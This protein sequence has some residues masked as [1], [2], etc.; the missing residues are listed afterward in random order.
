M[1]CIGKGDLD[2][3]IVGRILAEFIAGMVGNDLVD[4]QA[5]IHVP[6]SHENAK[7]MQGGIVGNA[8]D[9]L[10]AIDFHHLV[11]IRTN[12]GKGLCC[13]SCG[14]A[15]RGV[16]LVCGS[17]SH[18]HPSSTIPALQLKLE[19][20]AHPI[21]GTGQGLRAFQLD[22]YWSYG[23]GL[24]LVG[25]RNADDAIL[26]NC[27]SAVTQNI[28]LPVG[29]GESLAGI[30]LGNSGNR[31]GRQTQNS[32]LLVVGQ[33]QQEHAVFI[34]GDGCDRAAAMGGSKGLAGS[35]NTGQL[36]L[37]RKAQ[38]DGQHMIGAQRMHD[39]L[40]DGQIAGATVGIDKFHSSQLTR[41][42]GH[43]GTFLVGNIFH[44]GNF[45][46]LISRAG[47]HAADLQGLACIERNPGLAIGKGNGSNGGCAVRMAH[48]D[49]VSSIVGRIGN[50]GN[51]KCKGAGGIGGIGSHGLGQGNTRDGCD[52]QLAIVAQGSTDNEI[53]ASVANG[54]AIGIHERQIGIFQRAGCVGAA[55]Q[56]S[57]IR[58]IHMDI[59]CRHRPS[60]IAVT[61]G[62]CHCGI[63]QLAVVGLHPIC[64]AVLH[65]NGISTIGRAAGLGIATI[66]RTIGIGANQ[67]ILQEVIM[68]VLAGRIEIGIGID[69][70]VAHRAVQFILVGVETDI[71]VGIGIGGQI[72][73]RNNILHG[74][75]IDPV[76]QSDLINQ[77][78]GIFCARG[79]Q[80]GQISSLVQGHLV[81]QNRNQCGGNGEDHALLAGGDVF[82]NLDGGIHHIRLC[83]A[84]G[85]VHSAQIT[86]G[87]DQESRVSG[88]IAGRLRNG[89]TALM[90]ETQEL[91]SRVGIP[92]DVVGELG[93]TGVAQLAILIG[94]ANQR[95]GFIR[96]A[97]AQAD[98][99]RVD[100]FIAQGLGIFS[101]AQITA[102]GT[103]FKVLGQIRAGEQHMIDQN[104][105]DVYNIH[106]LANLVHKGHIARQIFAAA[107]QSGEITALQ[108]DI[109]N[110]L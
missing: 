9:G 47:G 78:D 72:F 84:V 109:T 14:K 24:I 60:S 86:I 8:I 73:R 55:F 70:A 46:H 31:A 32:H 38:A 56:N 23:L 26:G 2:I 97:Q 57:I 67:S 91:T 45:R 89:G 105:L 36:N 87:F 96:T 49:G 88:R 27:H 30:Q 90:P 29:R 18:I 28:I 25:N 64:I 35:A 7:G 75:G 81:G 59:A 50:I 42:D 104:A 66:Q 94:Q 103:F 65:I 92:T 54:M 12:S 62:S 4:L 99:N 106:I 98:H 21:G 82:P 39:L 63:R 80:T 79:G 11:V 41:Y 10:A 5:A 93:V 13:Q 53:V 58:Q 44:S 68:V 1:V 17:G 51:F 40:G 101:S 6:I 107:N 43:Q 77:A 48:H 3:P 110:D 83:H 71:A 37:H 69:L 102:I 22:I 61:L 16:S 108:L 76:I 85:F 52:Q 34:G 15:E 74:E 19:G 33:F 20:F 100:H 95:A